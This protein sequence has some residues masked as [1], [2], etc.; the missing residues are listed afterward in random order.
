[1]Y[2]THVNMHERGNL[3]FRGPSCGPVLLVLQCPPLSVGPGIHCG[4]S[5]T[6]SPKKKTRISIKAATEC[7]EA[8][9]NRAM[10]CTGPTHSSGSESEKRCV[11]THSLNSRQRRTSHTASPPQAP[12]PI[13]Y[14]PN[15][16]NYGMIQHHQQ[17]SYGRS[18]NGHGLVARFN[19]M[20]LRQGNLK[21]PSHLTS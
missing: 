14:T 16:S 19:S 5:I 3:R 10:R 9:N 17:F 2:T 1:M 13:T 8:Q 11:T 7:T 4:K 6:A 21:N 20:N 18:D 15:N 12:A